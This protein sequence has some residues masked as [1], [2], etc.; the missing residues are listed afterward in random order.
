VEVAFR[1]AYDHTIAGF[2]EAKRQHEVKLFLVGISFQTSLY[3]AF[4]TTGLPDMM[5]RVFRNTT[6]RDFV[7]RL[8]MAFQ[9][10]LGQTRQTYSELPEILAHSMSLLPGVEQTS[11]GAFTVAVP[12]EIKEHLPSF[13]DVRELLKANPWLVTVAMIGLYLRIEPDVPR[14]VR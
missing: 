9:A 14:A 13:D 10:R 2:V 5:D 6:V 8:T 7:F 3:M 4:T 11:H 1:D 12:D